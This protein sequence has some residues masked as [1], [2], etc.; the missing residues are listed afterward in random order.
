MKLFGVKRSNAFAGDRQKVFLCCHPLTP[1]RVRDRIAELL[2]DLADV[3]VYMDEEHGS[4]MEAGLDH[5]RRMNLVVLV[6]DRELVSPEPV[7]RSLRGCC[8]AILREARENGI[9]ILPVAV[10]REV[11]EPFNRI[12]GTLHC[13][14]IEHTLDHADE[15]R[16]ENEREL[17]KRG[18]DEILLPDERLKKIREAFE[19]YIFLSYRKKDR[20]YVDRL[21]RLLHSRSEFRDVA[22]WF[23]D[24]LQ[25]G[26]DFNRAILNAMDKSILFS[27]LVT[28]NLLERN[29]YVMTT[30]YTHA[31]AGNKTVLPVEF[32]PTD[33]TQLNLYYKNLPESVSAADTGGLERALARIA[34]ELKFKGNDNSPEHLF[35]IGLAYLAAVDVESD[36]ARAQTLILA[37]AKAGHLDGVKQ[38]ALMYKNGAG[39]RKSL[40]DAVYWQ[41]LYLR[42]LY[43]TAAA[44]FAPDRPKI[45]LK[46]EYSEEEYRFIRTSAEL[47]RGIALLLDLYRDLKLDI[48][49]IYSEVL[50]VC[51][52]IC[53]KMLLVLPLVTEYDAISGYEKVMGP[54][55]K[56]TLG[57][58]VTAKKF[59]LTG[60]VHHTDLADILLICEILI[61][62]EQKARANAVERYRASDASIREAE[63]LLS[64]GLRKKLRLQR[65]SDH[66]EYAISRF[67]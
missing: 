14:N 62:G 6:V 38:L 67:D 23:D 9:P 1:D 26:E 37:A 58:S 43:G 40:K 63:K 46:E 41:T 16:C 29:N 48:E 66:F 39:V 31:E 18:L 45:S 64:D 35:Y 3:V 27:L 53:Q 32:V 51:R 47:V 34:R 13:L 28:P 22:I 59:K 10:S 42:S 65:V 60:A 24:Y 7:S 11:L 33:R 4:H 2:I 55:G 8:D 36:H 54:D 56:W 12:F 49:R 17:L 44:L 25:P 50:P 20:E 61:L 30:E 19:A 15:I 57:K 21:M 52:L 5:I